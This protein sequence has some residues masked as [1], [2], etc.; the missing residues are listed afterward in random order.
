[1]NLKKVSGGFIVLSGQLCKLVLLI[2]QL[3]T[4]D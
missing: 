3:A 2:A 4:V 1:M